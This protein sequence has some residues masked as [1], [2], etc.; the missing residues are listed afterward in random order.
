M[1]D[2]KVTFIFTVQG[3]HEKFPARLLKKCQKVLNSAEGLALMKAVGAEGYTC[4]PCTENT[5]NLSIRL[6]GHSSE[7]SMYTLTHKDLVAVGAHLAHVTRLRIF[8]IYEEMGFGCVFKAG[9]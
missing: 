7:E 9:Y 4:A 3:E 1:T 6:S 8:L 2:N 5:G